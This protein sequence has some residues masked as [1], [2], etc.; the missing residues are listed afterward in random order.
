MKLTK[1]QV[2]HIAHLVR[3]ELTAEQAEKF[4]H[5]LS[6]ILDYMEILNEVDTDSVEET[7][8]VTGLENIERPDIVREKQ[9]PT[10]EELLACSPNPVEMNQIKVKKTI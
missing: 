5:Q 9:D 4:S 2:A 8:Q 1:E 7:N 10:T 6:D 3:L